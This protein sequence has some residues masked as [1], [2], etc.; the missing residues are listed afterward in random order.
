MHLEGVAPPATLGIEAQVSPHKA[1]N[2]IASNSNTKV[3]ACGNLVTLPYVI[4]NLVTHNPVYIPKGTIVAYA[5]KDEPKMDCFEIAKTYE[6][7]QRQCSTGIICQVIQL[8]LCHPSLTSFA[9]W[10]K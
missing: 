1:L 10:Q 5:K 8:H 7:A 9:P 3:S 6:E 2:P 4:Y